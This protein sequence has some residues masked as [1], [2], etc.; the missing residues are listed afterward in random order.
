MRNV[1]L[2]AIVA[3][4]LTLS[5]AASAKDFG[6]QG[7]VWNILEQDM[8]EYVVIAASKTDWNAVNEQLTDR[9]KDFPNTLPKRVWPAVGATSTVW[10]DPSIELTEDIQAPVK[11]PDGKL[12]WQVMIPKGTKVNPL[13]K[14]RPASALLFFDGADPAQLELARQA[15]EAFPGKVQPIEAGRGNVIESNEV[16]K[17]PVYHAADQV[18]NRFQVRGVPSL[19]YPG[20]GDRALYL[21]NTV[22][23]APF[24]PQAL[25]H[26]WPELGASSTPRSTQ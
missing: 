14:M 11:G 2:A 19:V 26:V 17:V 22:F 6:V 3:L 4:T 5:T 15:L 24:S 9:T 25:R 16:L 21:G 8:R 13:E 20:L 10:M 12:Q 1:A 18:I 7:T 23:V